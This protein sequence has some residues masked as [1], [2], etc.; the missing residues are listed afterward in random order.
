M[1][2]RS[3]S[4]LGIWLLPALLVAGLVL[5]VWQPIGLEPLLAWGEQIGSA[6]WFL[7]AVMI[8]IAVLFTF[9][10][11]GSSGLW[12]IAPFNHPVLATVLL[13]IA[14]TAG[15]FGAYRFSQRLGRDW[16]PSGGSARIVKLLERRGDLLT[17]LAL[18]MLPGFPHSV[19]NFA[20]GVL[21][22]PL[23]TFLAA[24]ALGLTIK[25]GIYATAIHGITDAVEGEQALSAGTVMPLFVLVALTLAGAW[26]R[27][28]M[29][30]DAT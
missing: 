19:I 6:W 7:T 14:S 1:S 20:S 21:G 4:G 10:L 22:L 13:V 24:T 29:G 11:P 5:A 30:S 25:W 18:R 27:R 8:M 15:G 23:A 16:Q 3:G 26:A 2:K 9:G 28:R 17:L 12:L